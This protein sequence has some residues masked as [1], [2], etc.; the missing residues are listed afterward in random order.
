MKLSHLILKVEQLDQAVREYRKEGF[1]IEY[2][3]AK[4][5]INALIYFS[6]GPYIELLD[7]SRMPDAVKAL[8][9]LLG[10]GAL[11]DRFERLDSCASGYRELALE[12]YGSNLAKERAVLRKHGIRSCEAPARR[13]DAHGRDLR[14]RIASPTALDIPFLMTYFSA[15]PKPKNFVHPNGIEQINRVVYSTNPVRFPLIR[16]LCDDERLELAST[17]N[18]EVSFKK[19]S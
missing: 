6:E 13:V 11:V 5:P 3:R 1:A 4:N 8:M 18:I 9:R 16:E 17:G 14:F 12:S 10:K 7:G 15:D 2:G 19:R